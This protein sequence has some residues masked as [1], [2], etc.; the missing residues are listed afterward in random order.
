MTNSKTKNLLLGIILTIAI[1]AC[2][3]TIITTIN[4]SSSD[5]VVY[6]DTT[7]TGK[8]SGK[9]D[10]PYLITKV[11]ELETF[12]DIAN[13]GAETHA[14]LNKDLTLTGTWTPIGT[15][16]NPFKGTFDGNCHTINGLNI[17]DTSRDYV[18][19]FGSAKGYSGVTEIKNLTVIGDTIRGDEYVGGIVGSVEGS[20]SGLSAI[21]KLNIVNCHNYIPVGGRL[22]VGGIVG[23]ASGTAN[24]IDC[25]NHATINCTNTS[26]LGGIVGAASGPQVGANSTPCPVTIENCYND[27]SISVTNSS[28]VGGILGT[29]QAR[30]N[31]KRCFNY[32]QSPITKLL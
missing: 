2:S 24:I 25:S 8:G 3:F 30:V 32:N 20:P 5:E 1:I 13:T 7:W 17:N 22:Y 18:G 27:G 21:Y 11:E 12:R 26:W 15:N 9:K 16:D 23:G 6:A 10:D 31:V 28:E 14:V 29:A 4:K 19:L